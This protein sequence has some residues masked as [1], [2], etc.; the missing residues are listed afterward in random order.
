[1]TDT[2]DIADPV[3]RA[4]LVLAVLV[5][6]GPAVG[7]LWLRA[8]PS[9]ARE[10]VLEALERAMPEAARIGPETEETALL[11]GVDVGASLTEGRRVLV[12]GLLSRTGRLTLTNAERAGRS[13]SAE[14]ARSLD[15]GG[16]VLVAI[17][18]GAE[19]DEAPAPALAA[20]LGLFLDLDGFGRVAA[21]ALGAHSIGFAPDWRTVAIP[22]KTET[23]IGAMA[24]G[25]GIADVRL[26]MAARVAARVLAAMGGR[27]EVCL[28]DVEGAAGLVL[29]PRG[30]RPDDQPEVE[31]DP[32]R[33]REQG[34]ERSADGAEADAGGD[35]LVDAV[36]TA[37]PPA[38]LDLAATVP[39]RSQ[40]GAGAG[41]AHKGNA[42][43][44]PL[45]SR[46]GRA[47]GRKRIDPV[48]TLRA[49]LPWQRLRSS[50]AEQR[51]ALRPADIRIRQFEER[52]ERLVIFAVDASGSL[53]MARMAEAKGAVECLLSEA[54]Q[55]RD[56]VALVAFR[57]TGAELLL[58][59]TRAL[60]R[61]RR[62]LQ[63]LPAGG[64]TPLAAGLEAALAIARQAGRTGTT[65]VV[66]LLSDGRANIARD[67]SA[68]R[69]NAAA[70]AE[71]MARHFAALGIEV[72][73]LDTGRRPEAGLEALARAAHGRYLAIPHG[74]ARTMASA[75]GSVLER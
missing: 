63:A 71:S 45:P 3:V 53:A 19:A 74:G 61:A 1:M 46:P 38:L 56:Q 54:Y 31:Q 59:P 65:P 55:K 17:D 29:A 57:G 11:G 26:L 47:D 42:R 8:R 73:V 43:G 16:R 9:P 14:I 36:R 75:V 32:S 24:S 39:A 4:R 12:P 21:E 35:R 72:L 40:S 5:A 52:T 23:I 67:G 44:R 22:A 13:L 51:V 25:L 62:A 48:A 49:A 20:R 66:V 30:I 2:A 27:D 34:D 37:L 7:G 15:E 33:E 69:T 58:P 60:V 41:R 64:G 68:D 28:A 50:P 18:E 70:D 10:A 6:A